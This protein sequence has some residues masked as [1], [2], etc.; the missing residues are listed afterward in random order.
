[1]HDADK[2]WSITTKTKKASGERHI[3]HTKHCAP[4]PTSLC[5]PN[6]HDF[7]TNTTQSS[8][9]PR[10]TTRTRLFCALAPIPLYHICSWINS[11]HRL[12]QI[13]TMPSPT[14]LGPGAA[15]YLPTMALSPFAFE[16]KLNIGFRKVLE[17]QSYPEFSNNGRDTKHVFAPTNYH[18]TSCDGYENMSTPAQYDIVALTAS[19]PSTPSASTPSTKG[20]DSCS[21]TSQSPTPSSSVDF[22]YTPSRSSSPSMPP[23]PNSY[24]CSKCNET[25]RL[26]GELNKHWNRKHV[27]RFSCT[28]Q[29]CDKAFHLKADLNRHIKSKHEVQAGIPCE[30][31]GC[32]ESFSRKD[33]MRRHMKEEHEHSKRKRAGSG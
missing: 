6:Y 30:Y 28:A 7:T 17:G 2:T 12:A 15:Q 19:T 1:M 21:N 29:D 11:R 9:H 22:T 18:E 8:S 27:K 5:I 3:Q 25:F 16:E 4:R 24:S 14:H 33:N 10:S 20:R 31:V 32:L 26:Q 23:P 13:L